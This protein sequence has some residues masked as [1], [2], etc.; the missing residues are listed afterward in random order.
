MNGEPK[1]ASFRLGSV[2]EMKQ[3]DFL[4]TPHAK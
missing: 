1:N 4:I 2:F 3:I